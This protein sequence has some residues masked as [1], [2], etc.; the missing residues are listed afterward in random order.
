MIELDD[1]VAGPGFA[2]HKWQSKCP[3]FARDGGTKVAVGSSADLT[4]IIG[5]P[6]RPQP[7]EATAVKLIAGI[8]GLLN[9]RRDNPNC[10]CEELQIEYGMVDP[11]TGKTPGCITDLRV[12]QAWALLEI[13]TQAGLL[14]A[15]GVG[16]GKTIL[17]LLAVWAMPN[18]R[19]AVLLVPPKLVKQ[20]IRDYR[21][22]GQHFKMPT[23]ITHDKSA[24]SGLVTGAPALH[25][26]PYS[27]LQRPE[28]TRE[29]VRLN[30][31]TIIA[32][33]VHKLKRADTATTGRVLR[34]F[35]EKPETRFCGWSGSLTDK[36]IKEYAHLSA[37]ALRYG[38]P[39]PVDPEVVDDWARAIDPPAKGAF[40]CPEGALTAL[41]NE[42]EHVRSGF[43]RRLVETPGVVATRVAAIDAALVIDERTPPPM[44]T[45]PTMH[46]ISVAEALR[47][48]REEW[49]R[50]DGMDYPDALQ[51]ARAALEISC[52]FFYRWRFPLVGGKPQSIVKILE[53]TQKRQDW[54]RE[55]RYAIKSRREHFDSERLARNAA[56]RFH[57]DRPIHDKKLPVW[58]SEFY[59]AWRDIEHEVVHETEAIWLDEWLAQDAAE[60]GL[61]HRGIIWYAQSAF[62]DKVAELSGLNLHAGGNRAEELINGEDG[63]RSII[64]SIKSHGT[65]RDGLQFK[66]AEQL[67]GNFPSSN[68]ECEQLLGRLH[69][70]GQKSGS[71]SANFYRHTPELARA[72]NTALRRAGYV[73]TTWGSAQKLNLS[74]LEGTDEEEDEDME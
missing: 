44:P 71:V 17:D 13:R 15:I 34:Y 12:V 59:P 38:S 67:I 32:D 1:L 42:G 63:K 36:S 60:W 19:T 7:D 49:K 51:R 25:V 54:N 24:F 70:V 58:G 22:V 46:D 33:E 69:R 41:C 73:E 30:P 21:I 29:L 48:L 23:M 9:L 55:V 6:R 28:C 31:D 10:K 53:W 39:L 18:C 57:G 4:R 62:G 11:E 27:K 16:H 50:P 65:G 5:L 66:F 14:G 74:G 3:D 26:L 68:E 45:Q 64:C 2:P 37:L 35:K 56:E 47:L 8:P 61:S 72:V 40:N 20:L 43:H 52:G